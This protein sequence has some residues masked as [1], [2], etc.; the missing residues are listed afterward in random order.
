MEFRLSESEKAEFLR[1]Q[2]EQDVEV[3]KRQG[4]KYPYYGAAGGAYTFSFT[5]TGLGTFIRVT[6]AVTKENLDL[7]LV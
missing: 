3:A 6:N 7:E 2:S 5:P 4:R 1:W